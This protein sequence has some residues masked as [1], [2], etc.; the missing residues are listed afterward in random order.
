MNRSISMDRVKYIGFDMDYTLVGERVTHTVPWHTVTTKWLM[1]AVVVYADIFF[2]PHSY[3][4]LLLIF[5]TLPCHFSLSFPVYKSPEYPQLAFDMT[6]Q[7]LVDIGYPSVSP[8]LLS[9]PLSK[10]VNLYCAGN[11]KAEVRSKLSSQVWERE[12]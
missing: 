2:F 3:H 8:S 4:P 9:L 5:P 1:A 11:I 7:R 12:S 6:V 10:A